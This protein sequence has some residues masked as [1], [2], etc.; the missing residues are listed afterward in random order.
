[1]TDITSSSSLGQRLFATPTAGVATVSMAIVVL[2]V[3]A[4]PILAPYEPT[5]FHPASRLQGP[6]LQFLL[7]TDEFGRDI[8]SRILSGAP[9]SI[10]FGLISTMIGTLIGAT[11]GLLAGYFGGRVDEVLM[12]IVDAIISVPNLLLVLLIVTVLGAS[13]T[14]AI[15]AVGIAFAPGIARVARGNALAIRSRDY[16]NAAR[17]RGESAGY[18]M[19]REMLPNL[20]S[21]IVIEASLRVAVAVLVGATLSYLGL[22]AQPPASDWG[23]LVSDARPYLFQNAWLVL[24]PAVFIAFVAFTFNLA[25]DA[26]RDALNPRVAGR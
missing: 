25:G 21:A 10:L 7:G 19:L 18:I 2:L 16:V 14:N 4:G 12:R 24:W 9:S 13:T 26:L 5:Q 22:G 3:V 20:V 8:L 23:L 15:L 17:A 11:L 6:S 1:M